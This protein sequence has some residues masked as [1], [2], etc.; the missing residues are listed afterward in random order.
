[1][2]GNTVYRIGF[3]FN[4]LTLFCFINLYRVEIMREYKLNKY[5]HAE[6]SA[7][8]DSRSVARELIKLGEK[9]QENI[10]NI[11]KE[12][13]I[14]GAV[15]I[16]LVVVNTAIS[17]YII[18]NGYLDDRE[19]SLVATSTMLLVG[20]LYDVFN[21]YHA[22]KNILTSAY[23]NQKVQFNAAN[24]DKIEVNLPPLP[25]GIVV[26]R[27]IRNETME[28][29]PRKTQRKVVTEGPTMDQRKVVTE[30]PTMDQRKI[31]TEGPTMDQ[32]KVV[33]EGPTMDQRK[34]EVAATP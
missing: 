28:E 14:T 25:K 33:T 5:L 4:F 24:L 18:V 23:R 12:Y 7:L 29:K 15:T 21:T 27:D 20:K 6:S 31:V 1:M 26:L 30:G 19:P 9:R 10:L 34:I 11:N 22:E 17:I 13:Q 16:C 3:V 2:N 32:R 8:N